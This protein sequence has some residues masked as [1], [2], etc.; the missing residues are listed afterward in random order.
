MNL[1]K[2]K[3]KTKQNK[4]NPSKT[5]FIVFIDLELDPYPSYEFGFVVF[6]D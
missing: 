3:K 2:K 5:Q 6:I 4:M 1:F